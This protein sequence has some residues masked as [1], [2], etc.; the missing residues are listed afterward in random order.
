MI[1][2]KSRKLR[3]HFRHRRVRKKISG[4]SLVPRV[5]VFKSSKHIY[6]QAIDD[7]NG[8][9]IC[10]ASS[11]TPEIRESISGKSMK[12]KD[13]AALVGEL[14][15][16]RLIEKGIKSIKFDRGGYPYHGRVKALAE[17]IREKGIKF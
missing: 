2:K 7:V 13:I 12:K 17:G 5:S 9:T 8:V 11:L 16:K 14:L 6:A 4:T 1:K 15:G 10:S 3:R